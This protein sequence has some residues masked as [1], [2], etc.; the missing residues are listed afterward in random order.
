MNF[1]FASY[2]GKSGAFARG[3]FGIIDYSKVFFNKYITSSCCFRGGFAWGRLF[4]VS[5]FVYQSNQF[6]K[7]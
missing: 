4:Q 6:N 1:Q 5:Q 3:Y 2:V 7:R